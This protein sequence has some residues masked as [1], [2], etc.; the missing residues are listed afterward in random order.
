MSLKEKLK[1]DPRIKKFTM[2]MIH[3]PRRPRP[4]LWI[5]LFVNP[6]FHKRGKHSLVRSRQ[7]RIDVMP[8][9]KF[10]VGADSIVESFTTINNGAG[11]VFIG[12]KCR[13]GIGTVIIGPVT[14]KDG[15]GTGQH[16]FMGGFNHGYKDGNEN[17]STQ[18]LDVKGIIIEEDAHIG[19]N[20]VIVAGVTIGKRCQI[21]AG[22]VVTK[23]IPPYSV[24]VGNP[25][26][27][28]KRFNNET[29]L[30]EKV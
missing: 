11:D 6:F 10:D 13:V 25:C 20:S 7:S 1:S 5:R 3:P 23:S 17:S 28:I 27:V 12:D 8:Y 9:N 2:W 19:A 18:A 15:S 29:K 30:W 24:A 22:S 26:R 4:R 16:V 14:M 21:G